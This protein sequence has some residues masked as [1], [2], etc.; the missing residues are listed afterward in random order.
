METRKIDEI[1]WR[2]DL[3]PRF[4]PNPSVIQKYAEDV[5]LLPPVEVNQ[6]N[7]FFVGYL[8]CTPQKNNK[9][10][11]FLV[12]VTDKKSDRQFARLAMQR[13]AMHGYHISNAEKKDWLLTWYTGLNDE[14]K[15]ELADDMRVSLRTVKR[16]TARKD[17]DL[18]KKQK[19]HAFDLWLSC[20]TDDAIAPEIGV[21]SK[22]TAKTYREEWSKGD[23]CQKLTIFS[24]YQDEK[25][26]PPIYNVWKKQAKS[27]QTSHFGNSEALFTDY[28]LY[29]YTDPFDVV[30]DPFAGGGST[31]N[32]CKHRLRRY[33][34]SD[35]V[36]IVE[37]RD[38]RQYDILDGPPPLHKR[39]GDVALLYLDPPYWKQAEGE[40]SDDTQDLAN[41]D[42]DQFHETLSWFIRQC[43]EKMKTGT[44][45]AMLMQPTQWHAQ[46]RHFS[47][48]H[49]FEIR[50]T[51]LDAPLRFVKTISAPYESQQANAQQVNWAKENQDVLEIGRTITVWEVA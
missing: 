38:I 5:E 42:L 46:D 32:L 44:H 48:D 14:E 2:E 24:T 45:I 22:T 39:W 25:W 41:M 23:T 34:V 37:R 30:V 15:Q 16:W 33:W 19:Q 29:L 31:I 11:N 36:P 21:D 13:N 28:L 7:D 17:K 8:G 18:K 10:E 9:Q 12:L 49:T 50:I 43:S 3:Y 51:L 35:R 4:E 1:I 40:Y 20:W 26:K 27:N 47:E 6:H